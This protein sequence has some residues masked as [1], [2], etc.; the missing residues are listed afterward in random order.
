[1]RPGRSRW[2]RA[3]LPGILSGILPGILLAGLP[4]ADLAAEIRVER[5]VDLGLQVSTLPEAKLSASLH[6]LFPLLR[7]TG[8]L[9]GSPLTAD[10]NLNAT[11]RGEISPVSLNGAFEAVFTPIAFF[12]LAGGFKLGSGWNITLGDQDIYGLGL[13]RPKITRRAE[14]LARP[15]EERTSEI[16]GYPLD[17]IVGKAHLGGAFQF[18]LAAIYPGDWHHLVF[19]TYHEVHYQ[20]Y[21]KATH[22]ESWIFEAASDEN[23]NGFNY[24]G[25]YLLGYRMP[26]VLNTLGFLAEM[27]RYLYNNPQGGYWGDGL[28][29]WIFSLLFNFTLTGNLEAALIVQTR[30]M[31]NYRDGDRSNSSRYYY[32]YRELD[33][34][35]PV[36]LDFYRVAA[37]FTYKLK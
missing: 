15:M 19:R 32:Q 4:A 5:S 16:K 7:D 25:N 22:G 31:R 6:Y 26:L 9:A 3:I 36:R 17:G 23:R 2:L 12:Q 1:M 14:A 27:D 21:T 24:Y 13:N 35:D 33:T 37:V 8:P 11:I 10:N 30:T 34:D 29:R 20:G 28:G 18:D